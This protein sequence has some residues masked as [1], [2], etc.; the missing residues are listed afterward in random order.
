MMNNS[1]LFDFSDSTLSLTVHEI[2]TPTDVEKAG[3]DAL[4]H[5]GEADFLF[6]TT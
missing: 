5:S 1:I 4:I 2:D 6:N 3:D